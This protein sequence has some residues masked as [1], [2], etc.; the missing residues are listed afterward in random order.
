MQSTR[1]PSSPPQQQK[2]ISRIQGAI[3]PL[4][5]AALDNGVSF[6]D[7]DAYLRDGRNQKE[8]TL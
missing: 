3:S 2:P 8:I 7:V 6:A 5:R 1:P 4:A